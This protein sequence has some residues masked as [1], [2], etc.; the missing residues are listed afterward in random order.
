MSASASLFQV[1]RGLAEIALPP[2]CALC[3]EYGRFEESGGLCPECRGSLER[4][5]DPICSACG[6]TCPGVGAAGAPYCGACVTKPPPYGRTRYGFVY[7]DRVKDAIGALKYGKRFHALDGLRELLRLAFDHYF[8]AGEFDV[9]VPVPV[10][11]TT[12]ARRGFNQAA[13]LADG[14][15]RYAGLPTHRTAV[16][17]S[18]ETT[19]QAQLGREA[20]RTN[21]RGVFEVARPDALK[22]KRILVVDDVATTGSTISEVCSAIGR[23]GP[24]SVDALA[25]SVRKDHSKLVL[26]KE[27]A[28]SMDDRF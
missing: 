19:P 14:L 9:I 20:R 12:L 3:G 17:K 2:S 24:L 4:V 10:H 18:R 16:V 15:T 22:A 28:P 25:L 7:A 6:R 23:A 11:R 1:I 26:Q 8:E 13:L 5:E 27:A 21:L